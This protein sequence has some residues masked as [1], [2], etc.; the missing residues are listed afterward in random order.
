M[1]KQQTR[2]LLRDQRRR[3]PPSRQR[4]A[5]DALARRL[6]GRLFFARARHIAFYLPNDGEID[7]SPLMLQALSRGKTAYLPVLDPRHPGR[8]TFMPWRPGVSLRA[9]RY[10]IPEPAY[11]PGHRPRLW[12]L[13]IVFMPLVGFDRLG[14]RLGMGGGFYDRTFADRAGYPRSRPLLVGLAHD[15]Q[16]V[17][18]L[19][20]DP[21]DIPLHAVATDRRLLYPQPPES[22]KSA[23]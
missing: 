12:M 5:S 4:R 6:E 9:N 14:N 15:F 17:D 2:T 20:A 23:P 8:L 13:D 3:L 11:R 22:R 19:A 10:G 16:Q 18:R 21:W 1:S 7:P